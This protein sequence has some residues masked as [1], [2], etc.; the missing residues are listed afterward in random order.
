MTFVTSLIVL[1]VVFFSS[2]TFA[3]TYLYVNTSGNLQGIEANNPTEAI[4]TASNIATHSGV[5]LVNGT[6]A[7]TY[8][9]IGGVVLSATS[10]TY[11]YID[12]S[13]N[14]RTVFA[15]NPEEAIAIAPDRAVHSGVV[16]IN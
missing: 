13:G 2:A 3:A 7:P 5:L 15:N 16:L 10:N 14:A 4:A 9:G 6:S 1:G 12:T 8:Y 11:L